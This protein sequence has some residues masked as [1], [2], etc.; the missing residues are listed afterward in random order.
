MMPYTFV[1]SNIDKEDKID[2]FCHVTNQD[3]WLQVLL[4]VH[5]I[6]R[7]LI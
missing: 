7:N 2:V 1:Y 5:E 3:L 6:E 4:G